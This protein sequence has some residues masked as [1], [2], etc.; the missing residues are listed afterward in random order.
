[1]RDTRYSHPSPMVTAILSILTIQSSYVLTCVHLTATRTTAM[2]PALLCEEPHAPKS[3][4]SGCCNECGSCPR[5]RTAALWLPAAALDPA[6]CHDSLP[7]HRHRS[8]W[9][10]GVISWRCE[11]VDHALLHVAFADSQG[12]SSTGPS[13]R[14]RTSSTLPALQT[15]PLS[16]PSS[17]LPS[18][19]QRWSSLAGSLHNLTGVP[20]SQ[21]AIT[22]SSAPCIVTEDPTTSLHCLRDHPSPLRRQALAVSRGMT[23][24]SLHASAVRNARSGSRSDIA[25]AQ[26]EQARR[27][28]RI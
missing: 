7:R 12:S 14:S 13:S 9:L 25:H 23:A 22:N 21:V 4:C 3:S 2:P 15:E 1:M 27:R 18:H 10:T 28:P 11:S 16:E 20:C 17:P 24:V 6:I 19:L 8:L 5:S 26:L